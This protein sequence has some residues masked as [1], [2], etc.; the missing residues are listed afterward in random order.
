M[1]DF[2]PHAGSVLSLRAL[3]PCLPGT[4]S[5][6]LGPIPA[7]LTHHPGHLTHPLAATCAAP[8]GRG[9]TPPPL[10]FISSDAGC[11]S[12][13]GVDLQPTALLCFCPQEL[14]HY[15]IGTLLLLI[16]SIV[17]ASKSYSQSEL[18]A[19]SVRI[20]SGHLRHE[21]MLFLTRFLLD[22]DGGGVVSWGLSF[23][24]SVPTLAQPAWSPKRLKQRVL[25]GKSS[26]LLANKSPQRP[27][28]SLAAST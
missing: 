10:L 6:L 20:S 7:S 12:A 23:S 8:V 24:K 1:V 17:A 5:L 15:L 16:A 18:V 2:C 21:S 25:G 19:A 4:C 27:G 22:G 26:G 14:L 28:L 9:V 11:L 3:P 13:P